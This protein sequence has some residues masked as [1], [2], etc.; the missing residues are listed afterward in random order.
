ML[1]GH[2]TA[3]SWHELDALDPVVQVM[4]G[5]DAAGFLFPYDDIGRSLIGQGVG[6]GGEMG[7]AVCADLTAEGLGEQG[8][9]AWV[10]GLQP[11]LGIQGRAP[12]MDFG[13]EGQAGGGPEP[14]EVYL[15]SVDEV[16]EVLWHEDHAVELIV[17][18][19]IQVSQIAVAQPEDITAGPMSCL[20]PGTDHKP[21]FRVFQLR[22]HLLALKAVLM[23]FGH[24]QQDGGQRGG[25]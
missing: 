5:G 12:T 15:A 10:A 13:I 14:A 25:S 17:L 20:V 21:C 2:V 3:L 19:D 9:G 24:K 23:K 1:R 6:D 4:D 18:G 8:H 22:H 11:D 7:E 16:Q